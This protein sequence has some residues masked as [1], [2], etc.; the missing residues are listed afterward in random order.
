MVAVHEV[1]EENGRAYLALEYADGQTLDRWLKEIA[2][3]TE[4]R[5][6]FAH[7]P[8]RWEAFVAAYRAELDGNPAVVELLALAAIAPVVTLLYAVRDPERNHAVVLS[9]YLEERA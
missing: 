1:G 2:P 6:W 8:S 9:D 7:D 4:L 3:S 5:V